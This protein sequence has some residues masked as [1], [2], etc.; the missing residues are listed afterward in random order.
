MKRKAFIGDI[1]GAKK[2]HEILYNKLLKYDLDSIHHMGDLVDRG[3]DSGGVVKFCRENAIEGILGNHDETILKYLM[4]GKPP[5]NPDRL[6]TYEA[7]SDPRD[8]DYLKSLPYF[9]IHDESLLQVHAGVSPFLPI[10]EQG[11]LLANAGLLNH[12]LPRKTKWMVE[13]Q[14]GT[15]EAILRGQGWKRWW[16]LYQSPFDII[17]GHRRSPGEQ[18]AYSTTQN[19]KKIFWT[20]TNGYWNGDLCALILPDLIVVS[21]K[22]ASF[23][24]ES[25]HHYSITRL[26]G[27]V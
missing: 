14:E 19:E 25:E 13:S 1:H 27:D 17:V 6:K 9:K 3:T 22:G 20:D 15:P 7:L 24:L 2:E 23:K 12:S 26:N 5:Q 21:S 11:T 4:K 18:I 10:E 8:V 16:D